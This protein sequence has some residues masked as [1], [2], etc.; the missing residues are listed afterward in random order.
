MP[1][2]S[3]VSA[4]TAVIEIGTCWTSSARFCAV[5]TISSSEPLAPS[6]NAVPLAMLMAGKAPSNAKRT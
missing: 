5:T 3:R 2:A 6:A 4:E 1:W